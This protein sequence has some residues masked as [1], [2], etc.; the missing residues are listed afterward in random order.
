MPARSLAPVVTTALYLAFAASSVDD[1]LNGFSVAFS[2]SVLELTVALAIWVVE[3]SELTL[4]SWKVEASS[5]ERVIFSEKVAVRLA[6]R[7]TPVAPSVGVVEAT[8]GD[9]RSLLS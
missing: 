3:P 9:L 6:P 5:V 1:E 8:E 4:K 7:F 2:P